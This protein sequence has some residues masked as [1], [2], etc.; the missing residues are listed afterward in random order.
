MH[1]PLLRRSPTQAL[2][3]FMVLRFNFTANCYR[4][5]NSQ[6]KP[7]HSSLTEYYEWRI[8]YRGGGE[9]EPEP[10]EEKGV[11]W[12]ARLWRSMWGTS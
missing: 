6:I 3:G 11:G 8:A 12:L 1:A 4:Q 10:V 7:L 9:V 5:C 2:A